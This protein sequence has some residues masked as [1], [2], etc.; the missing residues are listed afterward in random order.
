[1]VIC[2]PSSV[3]RKP[4]WMTEA[5]TDMKRERNKNC[6]KASKTIKLAVSLV[7]IIFLTGKLT[8]AVTA[9]NFKGQ[10]LPWTGQQQRLQEMDAVLANWE[11][12]RTIS[13]QMEKNPIEGFEMPPLSEY[14][15]SYLAELSDWAQNPASAV[16][17][18]PK[19]FRI[20]SDV[21]Y[22]FIAKAVEAYMKVPEITRQAF[23]ER[24]LV[25]NLVHYLTDDPY[26]AGYGDTHVRGAPPDWTIK[27]TTGFFNFSGFK[28]VVAEYS[29]QGSGADEIDVPMTS[30]QIEGTM[31]HELGHG[32]DELYRRVT[33]KRLSENPELSKAYAEVINQLKSMGEE[34][35]AILETLGYFAQNP[36]NP[37]TDTGGKQEFVAEKMGHKWGGEEQDIGISDPGTNEDFDKAFASVDTVITKLLADHNLA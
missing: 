33:G 11:W 36:K 30:S 1:M 37:Y 34:G 16:I 15:Q 19:G 32:M 14:A 31:L 10:C 22:A 23:E 4:G 29:K 2:R 20:G 9:K 17:T 25:I 18:L 12:L 28:A 24:G 27:T 21:S 6:G 7:V 35:Q 13:S 5:F 3:M 8:W 26:L